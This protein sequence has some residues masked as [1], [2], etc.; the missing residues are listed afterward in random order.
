MNWGAFGIGLMPEHFLLGGIV[1]LILLSV[2]TRNGLGAGELAFVAAAGAAISAAL[3]AWSGFS[4]AS[5][6]GQ[7]SV[8]PAAS[9]GKAVALALALPELLLARDDLGDTGP[10]YPLMRSSLCGLALMLSSDSFLTL[11][12]GLEL[13]S[14]PVYTL[15]LL[16]AR[17]SPSAEA[18]LKYIVLGGAAT[19]TLLMGISLL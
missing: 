14:L 2:V 16:G 15:V 5:F 11:F 3:L 19:A 9:L 17:R 7:L 13:M 8:D 4:G 12:L 6:P 18:A 10:L 1:R